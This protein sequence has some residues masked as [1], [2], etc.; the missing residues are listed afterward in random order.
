MRVDSLTNN[1]PKS[2]PQLKSVGYFSNNSSTIVNPTIVTIPS[3][4]VTGD[5][6]FIAWNNGWDSFQLSNSTLNATGA[7]ADG[8]LF[9]LGNT[10]S[11]GSTYN[12]AFSGVLIMANSTTANKQFKYNLQFN[13]TGVIAVFTNPNNT[14]TF[15]ANNM[16]KPTSA[17][18]IT[19][20]STSSRTSLVAPQPLRAHPNGTRVTIGAAWGQSGSQGN[21][22]YSGSG[23]F[24]QASDSYWWSTLGMAYKTNIGLSA[25]SETFSVSASSSMISSSFF[26]L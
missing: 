5:Y 2:S 15:H 11:T 14:T 24:S 20:K 26:I 9:Y 23:T 10:A 6:I 21:L 17:S 4:V 19:T 16:T 25:T 8:T 13:S 18:L 3:N 1:F 12:V 22:S 7:L